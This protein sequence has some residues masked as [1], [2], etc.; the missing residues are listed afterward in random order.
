MLLYKVG[1]YI[2]VLKIYYSY[3]FTF[4]LNLILSFIQEI[5]EILIKH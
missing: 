4:I 5:I 2:K 3:I 1:N